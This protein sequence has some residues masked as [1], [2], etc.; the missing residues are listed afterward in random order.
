MVCARMIGFWSPPAKIAIEAEVG[1]LSAAGEGP[2]SGLSWIWFWECGVLRYAGAEAWRTEMNKLC[3]ALGV[4]GCGAVAGAE[5]LNPYDFPSLG[6]VAAAPVG[7][8]TIN[9]DT[10]QMTV[11]GVGAPIV[12]TLSTASGGRGVVVFSFQDFQ[13]NSPVVPTVITGSRSVAILARN[14]VFFNST[15]TIVAGAGQA[16]GANNVSVPGVGG[17]GGTGVG[18]GGSGGSG[19][20]GAYGS[21]SDG[22]VPGT[23]GSGLGRGGGGTAGV[24]LKGGGGGGGGFGS[25]GVN[26]AGST[27]GDLFAR[28]EAGSGG[29]GGGGSR[30][31]NSTNGGTGGSGGGAGGGALEIGAINYAFVL[32]D[33]ECNGGSGAAGIAGF[34]AGGGGGG[35]GGAVL[36]HANNVQTANIRTLGGAG[37][38]GGIGGP[39]GNG[40]NGG[41]GGSGR[42]AIQRG[43]V[44]TQG[45][46]LGVATVLTAAV[47]A[48]GIDFG[49]VEVGT[50]RTLSLSVRSVGDSRATIN[51]I[52]PAAAAP[53]ARVGAGVLTGL[54]GSNAAACRYTFT[55][56]GLGD[57]QQQIA[58][59]T[60]AGTK[61]V[62][63]KG[64]GIAPTCPADF[65]NDGMVDDADFVIFV[66]EYNAL[67]C[68]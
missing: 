64:R 40:G 43:E 3:V 63:L 5:P 15:V 42:I 21:V 12:G 26:N 50:A 48:D 60:N 2:E 33:I 14:A 44:I 19:G 25:D 20:E 67:L 62:T 52:F 16:G 24:N 38:T 54:K 6:S 45:T 55:P 56:T 4:A 23:P 57:V 27:Y 61:V 10:M 8:V 7:T 59:Q 58:I 9:S 35:S 11:P 49:D 36:V 28:L 46:L 31:G 68:E 17:A 18:G 66:S 13:V 37:G 47:E 51:G 41:S 65:N 1:R 39:G 22:G 30:P 34:G 29:G 53:M 32:A